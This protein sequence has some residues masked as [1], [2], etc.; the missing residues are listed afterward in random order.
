MPWT[1]RPDK[2]Q[3]RSAEDS[4]ET[5][6]GVVYTWGCGRDPGTQLQ[7]L[8]PLVYVNKQKPCN[9]TWRPVTRKVLCRSWKAGES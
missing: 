7:A 4:S 2:V 6:R 8:Q 1:R 3:M 5:C 9:G